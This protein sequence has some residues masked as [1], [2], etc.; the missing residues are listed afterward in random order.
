MTKEQRP[1]EARLLLEAL[2]GAG[3]DFIVIGGLAV[4]AHGHPR[5][6]MDIDIVPAP[7]EANLARLATVLRDLDYEIAGV[8]EFDPDEV[9]QPDL[10][11]LMAGGSWVMITKHGG[12][13]VMQE[14]A[15][16][17]DY[18]ALSEEAVEDELFGVRIR[19]CGYRHLVAMKNA[20]GRPQDVAD[21]EALREARGES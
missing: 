1:L 7:E 12:L 18:R 20:A 13:D 11:G 19:F 10:E 21:I 4:A 2:V 15:P 8:E 9:V 6:T 14:V 17:L 16:E 5:A 3:V